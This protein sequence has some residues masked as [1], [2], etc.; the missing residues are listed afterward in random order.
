MTPTG[1]EERRAPLFGELHLKLLEQ[2]GP[3]SV[4]INENHNVIHLSEHAG[5]YLQF[6]GGEPSADLLKLAPP[7]LRLDLRSAIF[8]AGRENGNV[9]IAN[10]AVE[11]EGA[12]ELLDVHVR[13]LREGAES[14]GFTLVVFEKKTGEAPPSKAAAEPAHEPLTLHL[15]AE[16]RHTKEQLDRAVEQSGASTEELKASN[17]ELQAMNEELRSTT[18][19]L[20][21]SKEELQSVNEE[22]TT[23][24]Q[25]LKNNVE[26]LGRTN[27]DLQNL[28]GSTDIA[29]IFL[30]REL[31]I[32]CFTPRAQS[33]FNVLP[34]DIGRPLA[35]L[36]HRLQYE[37]L[38]EDAA[39]V[40]GNLTAIEREVLDNAGHCFLTRLLP[41]RTLDDRMDGVVLTFVDISERKAAEEVL[42]TSEEQLS[43][44]IAEAPVLVIMHAEDGQVLQISKS[45]TKLT[46]YTVAEMP[47][48]DAWLNR[49]YGFGADEV[50]AQMKRLFRGDSKVEQAEFEIVTRS[51]ERRH[52]SF[53]A[54]VPGVLRDGRRFIIA[55]ALDITD[56]YRLSNEIAGYLRKFDA[57]VAAVPD[58]ICCF[59]RTGR[60]TFANQALLEVWGKSFEETMGKDVYELDYPPELAERIQRQVQEVITTGQTVKDQTPFIGALGL[61]QYE[62]IFVPLR[63][64]NGEVEEVAGVTRDITE[65]QQAEADLL[66]AKDRLAA[67]VS[68]MA[69]L[70]EI[71]TCM[72]SI[73]TVE[74][75]L[76]QV[77]DA[78]IELQG[79]DFGS[80]QLVNRTTSA[81]EIVA[82][83][84]F[85]PRLLG[86]F[87]GKPDSSTTCGRALER[88]E[89]VIIEDVKKD[90]AYRKHRRAAAEAGYRAVQTTLLCDRSGAT[91]GMLSTHFRAPHRPSERDL[92]LTDLYATQAAEI[93]SL[94]MAESTLRESR[95]RFHLLVDGA[96]DYAM[97]LIEPD[98][99]ISYWSAGAERIFGWSAEEAVGQSGQLIFTP[100]DRA[101]GREKKERAI[102]QREGRANDCRWHMRKDGSRIWVDGVMR[103]LDDENGNLRGFAKVARD[104]TEQRVA[105]EKLKRSHLELERRVK[106]RT[107]E[108]TATNRRLQ[109]EIEQRARLEQEILLISER[110]K[111]RIGQ[112]LH[113]SLCQELAAAAFF[114]QSAAHQIEKKNPGAAETLAAA[115]KIVN[116]NVGLAR[117]LARGLHPVDLSASGLTNALRELAF[118]ASQAPVQCL[119]ECPKPIRVRDDAVAL[120][121]YRIAQEAVTNAVKNGNAKKIVIHLA[122]RRQRLV[123]TV[124]DNGRGFAAKKASKGMGI[125]IMKYRAEVIG[126]AL[127]VK[128]EEGR[129]ATVTCT[130]GHA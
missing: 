100:E 23:V 87:A 93:V 39:A 76:E 94:K 81:L 56:R 88:R 59:D 47:T 36:T 4:V 89:R 22:L 42:Q 43:R 50:R 61:R 122:R 74:L 114:L 55:M 8:R 2:Y 3:P 101:R 97:F 33:L 57:M 112:D 26:E 34:A 124:A 45:W 84:G 20:E 5:R 102:A 15:E 130:L 54:S 24:N 129:G 40:L 63:G 71:S 67:E 119:F 51:G 70:H 126:G 103:R 115:A 60:F 79:A 73:S 90:P 110:E 80:I 11:V 78:V 6:G 68:A 85:Q 95:E 91:L 125:H 58:L 1:G 19:E 92:R 52:W 128:S 121:L 48:F 53:S 32:N 13:P 64:D 118:R 83:R 37:Q 117:D 98:N 62:Y 29:T 109:G 69:R 9:T 127:I 106:T 65:R 123:L 46:G 104:A 108:L 75:L 12:M 116:A 38:E 31:R 72:L 28:I 16:L 105:E 14:P 30:N 7:A 49:A 44:A 17:Q 111:R 41:Y 10:V 120:H 18:E 82:S 27:S 96:R 21:T 99:R 86:H 66:A 107:A 35:H 25:E 77:L 113:D